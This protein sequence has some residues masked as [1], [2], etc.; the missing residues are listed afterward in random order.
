[1]QLAVKNDILETIAVFSSRKCN[2]GI[3]NKPEVISC[4]WLIFYPSVAL[5]GGMCS[6]QSKEA[7]ESR[8]LLED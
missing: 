2:T 7:K 6:D 1:M 5:K 3:K 4:L 8:K